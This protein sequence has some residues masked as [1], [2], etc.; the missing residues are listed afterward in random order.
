MSDL[1][2]MTTECLVCQRDYKQNAK[3]SKLLCSS[4]FRSLQSAGYSNYD[5]IVWAAT[6][7]LKWERRHRAD[8]RRAGSPFLNRERP[9]DL[10]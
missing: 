1:D 8:A 5:I 10:P 6:R 9:H 4:C 3:G 7:A 2:S